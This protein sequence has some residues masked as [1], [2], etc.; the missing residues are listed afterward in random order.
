[1]FPKESSSKTNATMC[2]KLTMP[3]VHIWVR[4]LHLTLQNPPF[5]KSH[6]SVR[7]D[8]TVFHCF[9][10][11]PKN[12]CKRSMNQRF[13]ALGPVVSFL[14]ILTNISLVQPWCPVYLQLRL[15]FEKKRCTF[16]KSFLFCAQRK[17]SP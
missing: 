17:L 13:L 11:F 9:S 10:V 16:R 1:M 6:F 14:R 4:I 8:L 5:P 3:W 12:P 2:N 7:D 15:Y